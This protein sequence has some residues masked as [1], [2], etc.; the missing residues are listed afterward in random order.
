MRKPLV[1]R[2]MGTPPIKCQV[3]GGELLL[4]FYDFKN[5]DGVWSIGCTKCF[6]EL[7]GH[8]GSGFGQKYRMGDLTR[9]SH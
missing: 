9:V 8:L 1:K 4:Y 6:E 3:C 5:R 7:S 2:W